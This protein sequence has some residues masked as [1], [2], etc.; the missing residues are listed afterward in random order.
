M[1]Q[2]DFTIS[3][4]VLVAPLDWGLGHAT[5]CIP[6]IKTLLKK[7]G[8]VILA[9]EGKTKALLRQE[10]PN[11]PF[12]DLQGY[13]VQYSK[14]KWWLPF[15]M[16]GQIPKILAAIEAEQEWL[17]KAVKDHNITAIISDNRYGLHHKE[18]HSV[19]ITHQLLI[20]TGL[21][22]WM[23]EILQ[24]QNYGYIN[25]FDECW[26][27][28][29]E[30]EDNLAGELSHPEAKP[31]IPFHY[32]GPLTRFNSDGHES[33][34]QHLLIILSGP[35]PQRTL[36]EEII[37]SQINDVSNPVVLVRGLPDTN[38]TIEAPSHVKVYNHIAAQELE[39]LI[40]DASLVISRCGYSTVMDLVTLKKKSIL[41]PTPGQ[42]EQEYL[43]KYLMKKGAAFFVEQDKF[44]L[45]NVLELANNFNYTLP[46]ISDTNLDATID[47]F[48]TQLKSP[49][50]PVG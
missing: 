3:G 19:F 22:K 50:A 17:Q 11:L 49:S 44:R 32:I 33:S 40:R 10:F 39:Q 45:M 43:A 21:G 23:D 48:L 14:E 5:R 4:N 13:N 31:V 28:D 24:D 37:L 2:S 42:T 27:P 6:I 36:L 38:E 47:R 26:I 18:V 7:N 46:N 8:S 35:E 25:R 30:G 29:V 12:L 16:A 15:H 20:K 41:I 34:N 9:A 1:G